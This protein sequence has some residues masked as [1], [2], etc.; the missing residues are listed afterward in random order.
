[1]GLAIALER[2]RRHHD[3][4]PGPRDRDGAEEPGDDDR[5]ERGPAA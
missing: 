4:R 5:G 1:M 2:A 3:R